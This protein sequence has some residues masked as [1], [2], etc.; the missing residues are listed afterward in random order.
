MRAARFPIP[1]RS[2]ARLALAPAWVA[3]VAV[4]GCRPSP[5]AEAG[6]EVEAAPVATAPPEMEMSWEE[7]PLG[8]VA[9]V[10]P[11]PVP[12]TEG[13]SPLVYMTEQAETIRVV[14]RG[15]E[16]ILAEAAVP[17]RTIVRV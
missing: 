13:A 15:T 2:L 6:A 7:R 3:S 14:E 9:S 11:A 12:V 10:A 16:R 4:T 1:L 17:A 5:P 8:G